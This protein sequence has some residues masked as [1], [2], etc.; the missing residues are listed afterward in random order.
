MNSNPEYI[1]P[2]YAQI[3]KNRVQIPI[4]MHL[5]YYFSGRTGLSQGISEKLSIRS[6]N[7]SYSIK[8]VDKRCWFSVVCC[9]NLA[10][11]RI[12]IYV[13]KVMAVVNFAIYYTIYQSF[14]K[15]SFYFWIQKWHFLNSWDLYSHLDK[16]ILP[17][18]SNTGPGK[19]SL[20]RSIWP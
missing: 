14:K 18:D 7:I 3:K 19:H 10:E 6:E 12:K 16:S 20:E 5:L 9:A 4:C 17:E 15:K 2:T 1:C 13:L 8:N 11:F